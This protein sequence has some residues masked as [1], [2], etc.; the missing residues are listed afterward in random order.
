MISMYGSIY[1]NYGLGNMS[2]FESGQVRFGGGYWDHLDA[3]QR[4]SP[5][6]HVTKVNTP[7]L[8]LHNDKDGAVDWN[9]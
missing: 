2:I 6:Y 5:V 4:N 8:I 7:L 3:Y 1:A 9:Q